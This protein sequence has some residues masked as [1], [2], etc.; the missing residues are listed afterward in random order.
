MMC[1]HERFTVLW[2]KVISPVYM[3]AENLCLASV[4]QT[5]ARETLGMQGVLRAFRALFKEGTIRI[6][7]REASPSL[8]DISLVCDVLCRRRFIQLRSHCTYSMSPWTAV[9]VFTRYTK[10]M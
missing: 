6:L 9:C 3:S 8:A 4:A 7:V 10:K 5:I 1:Q 2:N